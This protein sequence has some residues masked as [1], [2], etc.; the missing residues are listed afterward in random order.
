MKNKKESAFRLQGTDGIRRE[1]KLA[2]NLPKGMSPQSVFLQRGYLTEE[3][4]ELYSYAQTTLWSEKG[5]FDSQ[6]G[7]VIGWDP[8]DASG[9]FTASVVRGVRRAG[10]PA[11]VL[12]VVPTPL[13]PLY[14]VY[15]GARGG[16]MAT[17]SHNPP[18][19]NGIKLF[20]SY[21]G[22]KPF[23]LN[24]EE[25]SARVMELDYNEIKKLPL[26][27]RRIDHRKKALEAFRSFSLAPENSWFDSDRIQKDFFKKTI[28]VVD[29]ANGS[30]SKLATEIFRTVGF[31]KVYEVN[32]GAGEVNQNGG[33][34][35]LEGWGSISAKQAEGAFSRHKA[36]RKLFEL[37][38]KNR[39]GIL[40]G[41]LRLWGAVFDA[42]ADRFYK[43]EYQAKG[44]CLKVSGGD[45][46]AIIQSRKLIDSSSKDRPL[47][48]N[49][50]ES[51]LNISAAAEKRGLRRQMTAVGDKW[52]Q[53]K[54]ALA[55][56]EKRVQKIKKESGKNLPSALAKE[57]KILKSGKASPDVYRLQKFEDRLD[58]L[59]EPGARD[60]IYPALAL[61]SEETGHNITLGTLLRKDGSPAPVFFGNGLKSALNTFACE[62]EGKAV[63]KFR[64]GFKKTLYAY[65]IKKELFNNNSKLWRKVKS[66]II[67]LANELGWKARAVKFPEDAEMLYIELMP[68]DKRK[69][70][71]FVRNSGTENKIGVN[72]RSAASD[73]A[74]L[75]RCGENILRLLMENMK[76]HDSEWRRLELEV[77][78]LLKPNGPQKEN[79]LN[80]EPGKKDRLLEEMFK[81]GL[82]DRVPIGIKITLLGKRLLEKT[83]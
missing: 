28:L 56:I 48:F 27:G 50:V 24:D 59:Q 69:A 47:F 1:I 4:M 43:L 71:I 7:V 35:Q 61:G 53:L 41:E 12:G 68:T 64:P 19:Q 6:S 10:V 66:Q 9:E 8:R 21:R 32:G 25:L 74:P 23:P 14:M 15:V 13:V 44:D 20:N 16:V 62:S 17:A 52:I 70:A 81:Q 29:P 54:F 39:V 65:Y 51:D 55:L 77:L 42:D 76:D 73:S 46:T 58:R 2:K 78:Q 33:V 83:A 60:C 72:L 63:W 3:F 22:M 57:W 18:D 82:I 80:I 75:K 5:T 38:R 40:N 26:A 49:T 11:W 34:A 31:K 67:Q 36:V 30:L 79:K 37:G 45:D